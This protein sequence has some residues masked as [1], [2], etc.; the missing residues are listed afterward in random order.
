M[1][2]SQNTPF[3]LRFLAA[4]EKHPD[5]PALFAGSQMYTYSE[6]HAAVHTVMEFVNTAFTNEARVGVVDQNDLW[7]YASLIALNLLGKTYVPVNPRYPEDRIKTILQEAS[8]TCILSSADY[9]CKDARVM[10]PVPSVPEKTKG[11]FPAIRKTDEAAYILFTSGSTGK[12]KG[13]PIFNHHL[14]PFFDFFLDKQNY[15]F[16]A[17]DRFLQV[18]ETS[19]DV[20]VFS[21]F[22]PLFSGACMYLLPRK[23]FIYLEIPEMLLRH[24]ITVV[25]MVPSIL[26]YLQPYLPELR[27]EKLRYSF[28]SGDKLYHAVAKSW[29]K[30]CFNAAICNCYGPT[31]TTIVCSD[32]RWDEQT[33]EEESFL[34]I[35]PIGKLFPGM[36][37]ML[38]DENG[39]ETP[40]GEAGELCICGSQVIGSY[41][42]N[43]GEDKFFEHSLSGTSRKYYRTGD[44]V[45]I[46]K[47]GNM[48][49]VGRTDHQ[50]KIN[51]YRIEPG[52]IDAVLLDLNGN[53]L[54]AIVPVQPADG[55]MHLI[56]F[57]EGSGDEQWI[58][59]ELRKRLPPQSIPRQIV[60]LEKMPLNNNGKIDRKELIKFVP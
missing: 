53:R 9:L 22:T 39:K 49:Y 43:A 30:S 52:E 1:T 59:S 48:L 46:N 5:R 60:F 29:S 45:K 6:L 11:A 27:F 36:E 58:F 56:A 41:L 21:A 26:H 33:A 24:E 32:Y 10:S 54:C 15:D 47:A 2:G 42:N 17:D 13:V 23:G 4:F 3:T 38:T 28:F 35:V 44:L 12:P 19:F 7:T 57:M 34:G 37:L 55:L 20:S 31:E 18:Y 40:Q 50:L 25:S 8:V 51:G 16:T 14:N